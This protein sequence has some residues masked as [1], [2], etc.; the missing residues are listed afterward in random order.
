MVTPGVTI[1]R[2]R[3]A[4]RFAS[5]ASVEASSA[6]AVRLFFS[7]S[8]GL[9]RLTAKPL[10][11]AASM[12]SMRNSCASRFRGNCRDHFDGDV[13]ADAGCPPVAAAAV[14]SAAASSA[15][16]IAAASVGASSAGH[17]RYVRAA[18]L[19]ARKARTTP[20]RAGQLSARTSVRP[21]GGVTTTSQCPPKNGG[22]GSSRQT[23]ITRH[24]SARRHRS[25]SECTRWQTRGLIST[26]ASP[27]GG[28]CLTSWDTFSRS[29]FIC[30]FVADEGDDVFC[31]FVAGSDGRWLLVLLFSSALLF[32][33]LLSSNASAGVDRDLF[34]REARSGVGLSPRS[35]S[36]T[37]YM[38]SSS[39]PLAA[40][41]F[42]RTPHALH[43]VFGPLGPLRQSGVRVTPQL[44]HARGT[45]AWQ[46]CCRAAAV[47][48]VAPVRTAGGAV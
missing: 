24:P 33:S 31:F 37:S 5:I 30:C 21:S 29:F 4:E 47:A 39:S 32:S 13:V 41:R 9:F 44:M 28:S 3:A 2:A 34:G 19:S 17:H 35:S 10:R 38:S 48:A 23:I 22:S 26:S 36:P 16:T 43:S 6:S 11:C 14:A 1:S 45:G 18:A 15:T 25:A 27:V 7:W 40:I 12:Q 42:A 8:A 46:G 20:P